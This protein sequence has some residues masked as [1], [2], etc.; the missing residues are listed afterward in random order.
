MAQAQERMER[1]STPQERK[2]IAKAPSPL[3]P[4]AVNQTLDMAHRLRVAVIAA[5][6]RPPPPAAR[7]DA[8]NAPCAAAGGGGT[9]STSAGDD[10]TRNVSGV[11]GRGR[12]GEGDRMKEGTGVG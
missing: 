3:V 1:T 5:A 11:R 7:P 2:A 4:Q 8:P 10:G 6:A 12:I 9:V